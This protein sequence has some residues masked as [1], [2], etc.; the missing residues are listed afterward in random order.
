MKKYILLIVWAAFGLIATAQSDKSG[1]GIAVGATASTN[2]IGGQVIASLGN[3]LGVR[4]GYEQIDRS[5]PDAF[6][7]TISDIALNISP[8]WKAGGFSAMVDLYLTR[9]LFVSGGIINTD[10]D[11]SARLMSAESMMVGEIEYTPEDIG[12]L[13]LSI[14]PLEKMSPYVSLG[15]GRNIARNSGLSMSLEVGAILAKAYDIQMSG[16]NMFAGNSDNESINNLVATLNSFEWSGVIPMIKLS[17]AYR[18]L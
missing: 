14:K 9:G 12:E 5:F 4:V 15:F 1:L 11:L 6:Q 7:Y 16:T 3:R 17:I 2:G 18:I 8:S 10:F 13:S